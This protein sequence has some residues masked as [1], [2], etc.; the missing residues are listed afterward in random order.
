MAVIGS[1]LSALGSIFALI[2]RGY[3]PVI[4]DAGSLDDVS[5]PTNFVHLGKIEPYEWSERDFHNLFSTL[6][7]RLKGIPKKLSFGSPD[8]YGKG[9][10]YFTGKRLPTYSHSIGGLSRIWGGS[11]LVTPREELK[12]WPISFEDLNPY[13]DKAIDALPY[14][15]SSSAL[16]TDFQQ[17]RRNSGL[18]PSY[19]DHE[20][21]NTLSRKLGHEAKIGPARLLV[22]TQGD[23]RCRYCGL[24]MVGCVYSSIFQSSQVITQLIELNSIEYIDNHILNY[25]T[26][27]GQSP[28]LVFD[29]CGREVKYE[30]QFDKVF[31]GTGA[32][33]TAR[34]IL[35][36][37]SSLNSVQIFGRGSCVI[38]L[39][40]LRS[41]KFQWPHTNSLPG[42][43]LE[44]LNKKRKSWTHI[45][46]SNQNELVF[47]A[48]RILSLKRFQKMR[49]FVSSRLSTVMINNSS[50]FGVRYRLHKNESAEN[51]LKVD[52]SLVGSR[53]RF[54][55]ESIC[56]TLKISRAL[57]MLP[58]FFFAKVNKQTYH[59]G[60]SFPMSHSRQN[61]TET[62]TLGRLKPFRNIHIVD[63]ST[64]PSIPA[65]T[66]G[67]LL[68]ANAWRITAHSIPVD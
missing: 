36:S 8:V 19:R 39:F 37:L 11:V 35:N 30:N 27:K 52:F 31:L 49:V 6:N 15:A 66:I 38:P 9:S 3:K 59:L 64:F 63:S 44:F 7:P 54:L 58:L 62:D 2:E 28:I 48:L 50:S 25:I 57:T 60:G 43:F 17:P 29:H 22:K 16:D 23:N 46:M 34:I 42:I 40:S 32:T 12:D 33:E 13:F 47:A 14:A 53:V 51:L 1:G 68:I 21:L 65:T 45:Q 18:L 5:I 56:Y 26:E 20:Y 10:R 24:C 4:F 67:L 41:S 55:F 61:L